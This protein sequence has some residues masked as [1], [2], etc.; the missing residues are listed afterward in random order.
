MR[1][2][3]LIAV[4]LFIFM[5]MVLEKSGVADALYTMMHRWMGSLRGGLA[6]GTVL[7]CTLFA[8]MSGVSATGTVTMGIIALP[9][10]L[11]RGYD[12]SIAIG[13]I[14][15]GGALGVLIP[16]SVIMIVYGLLSQESVGQLFAGGV[17]PGLLFSFLFM[18]YIVIKCFLNPM[19]GPPLSVQERADWRLKFTSLRAVILPVFLV[20]AVL[21]SI[22]FGVATPTESS[23]VGALGALI[24]AG[25]NRRLNWKMLFESCKGTLKITGMIM[26][27]IL[28]SSIFVAV[29]SGLGSGRLVENLLKSFT[30]SPWVVFT[31]IQLTFFVLGCF[32]DPLG[33]L[34]MTTPVFLPVIKYLG[35]NPMWYGVIFVVNM[36]MAFLTPPFGSNLFYMRGVAPREVSMADIYRSITPF[37]ILQAVGLILCITFPEIVTWLPG[38]FFK[39]K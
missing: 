19:L 21:G 9:N 22:F 26:W 37:V 32:I 28:A 30:M 18:L 23:A 38:L 17:F 7:I 5:A 12:K 36:E 3:I 25:I 8:A 6:I 11:K 15:A 29:Y 4:P 13:C 20:A 2:I 27:I 10:M 35:F 31:I 34:M 14:M 1:T 16:P 39:T 24:C 33:I